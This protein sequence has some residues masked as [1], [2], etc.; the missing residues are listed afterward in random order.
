MKRREFE[1]LFRKYLL[2]DLPDF[3]Y[4][5][6]LLFVRPV[7]HLLRGFYFESSAFDADAFHVWTFVQPLYVPSDCVIFNFGT[8]LY[9][10]WGEGWTLDRQDEG[11]TMTDVL[12]SI[13]EKGLPFLAPVQTP[14]DLARKAS[15]VGGYPNT[16]HTA[17]AVA[18]SFVLAH[19]YPEALQALDRFRTILATHD[20]TNPWLAEMQ[21]RSE[22]VRDRLERNPHEAIELLEEWNEQTRSDLRLPKD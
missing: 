18:Y 2:A 14:G 21:R 6:S 15:L 5:G 12:V 16:P 19:E 11:A 20:L 3:A 10:R 1:A 13:K 7:V 8:R 17:E 4:R 22:L 9:G